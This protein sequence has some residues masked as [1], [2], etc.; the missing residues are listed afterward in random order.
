[1]LGVLPAPFLTTEG[2][3]DYGHPRLARL[4]GGRVSKFFFMDRPEEQSFS[5]LHSF[6]TP[7]MKAPK[8]NPETVVLDKKKKKIVRTFPEGSI[9]GGVSLGQWL[10]WAG[11]GEAPA[12]GIDPAR[13]ESEGFGNRTDLGNTVGQLSPL[14]RKH[15]LPSHREGKPE[16][17][18]TYRLTGLVLLVRMR[19]TNRRWF[20][21]P[22]DRPRCEITLKIV[23]QAWGFMDVDSRSVAVNPAPLTRLEARVV[24]KAVAGTLVPGQTALDAAGGNW[25]YGASATAV[26]RSAVQPGSAAHQRVLDLLFS[27][28][29]GEVQTDVRVQRTGVVVRLIQSGS[30]GH[31]EWGALIT[32]LV[33]GVVLLNVASLVTDVLAFYLRPLPACGWCG[34]QRENK[35]RDG[36]KQVDAENG[37]DEED[38]EDEDIEDGGSGDPGGE[39]GNTDGKASVFGT[40]RRLETD[41]LDNAPIEDGTRDLDPVG[42][43]F[44]LVAPS[45][46]AEKRPSGHVS[47]RPDRSPSVSTA[48]A[49]A[50]QTVSVSVDVRPSFT[51]DA[52]RHGDDIATARDGS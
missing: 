9:V 20:E 42:S 10:K 29:G 2:V 6:S 4:P 24:D 37:K 15:I 41:E 44:G 13:D 43:T 38:E 34:E 3:V 48:G 14:D 17:A 51:T 35:D 16:E 45:S 21:W 52:K 47:S 27:P 39:G 28:L 7:S 23:P 5:V 11:F 12:L 46:S 19:Y 22:G 33:E 32:R 18:P 26:N 40:I 25:T 50:R 31:F 30:I 8:V 1:M 36:G 49:G